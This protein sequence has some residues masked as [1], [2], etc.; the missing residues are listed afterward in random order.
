VKRAMQSTFTSYFTGIFTQLCWLNSRCEPGCRMPAIGMGRLP[1]L[2]SS[3]ERPRLL[4]ACAARKP[5]PRSCRRCGG[6][7]RLDRLSY[8]AQPFRFCRLRRC[9]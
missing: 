6:R 8:R 2:W 3:R 9:K 1:G 5:C 7:S 4:A